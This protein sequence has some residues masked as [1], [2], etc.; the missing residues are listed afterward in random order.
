VQISNARVI[1]TDTV[2][3]QS[4]AG[5]RCVGMEIA[6][7]D[8]SVSNY[9]CEGAHTGIQLEVEGATGHSIQNVALSNI[10]ISGARG[11]D[12][13]GAGIYWTGSRR[14]W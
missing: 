8:V 4:I 11:A 2:A 1:C 13:L 5:G 9:T 10:R 14:R 12:G 6:A 3:N 7:Q